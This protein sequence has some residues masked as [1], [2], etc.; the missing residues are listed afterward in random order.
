[1]DGHIP[2]LLNESISLLEVKNS[3][4]YVD[5]T[6]GRGGHSS[7]LLSKLGE[8]GKLFAFDLDKE[9]IAFGKNKFQDDKRINFIHSSFAFM[10]EELL[11]KGVNKVDGIIADLGV[12]SPQLD[13]PERGFSYRFD[14]PLDMRMNQD[15]KLT[16]YEVVN[17]YPKEKLEKILF[18][19]GEEKDSKRIVNAILRRREKAPIRTTFELVEA[20]KEG[21]PYSSLKEKGHPAKQTFQA[22]R[23][24]VNKEEEAL[25]KI[26]E[27]AP[28][29]LNLN[30]VLAIITFMSIDDRLVKKRFVELSSSMGSRHGLDLLPNQIE[31][32]K[33]L[34]LSKKPILPSEEEENINR[35]SV[36]AK[37]RGLK[38]IAK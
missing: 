34:N 20:I 29:L 1:M 23:I 25:E 7:L 15:S 26:L 5:L 6:F 3:G 4:I 11:E 2:V 13:N 32:P 9:A 19:Y 10:K 36:S 14:A 17:S 24:E 12:S 33:F 31:K 28:E 27:D 37:L 8:K 16:A 38:R 30:G 22:I 18:D 35:R 21:K